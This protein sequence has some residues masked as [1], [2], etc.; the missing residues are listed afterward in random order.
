MIKCAKCGT[1]IFDKDNMVWECKS[2]GKSFKANLSKLKKIQEQKDKIENNGKRLLKCS[3]CGNGLDDGDEKIICKCSECENVIT[4]N[5]KFFSGKNNEDIK[6]NPNLI[7]CP[8]CGRANVSKSAETCPDCG[9]GIKA[10]EEEKHKKEELRKL[11]EK[12][13]KERKRLAEERAKEEQALLDSMP[14]PQK[15]FPWQPLLG[16]FFAVGAIF[17]FYIGLMSYI[18][19]ILLGLFEGFIAFCLIVGGYSNYQDRRRIY[20]ISLHDME[21]A[22]KEALALDRMNQAIVAEKN[23][24]IMNAVNPFKEVSNGIKCPMC[25]KNA[26]KRISTTSRAVSVATV[27]LASG[28]IGKQYKCSSCGHMW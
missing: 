6:R 22:K 13:G 23:A 8:E 10:H 12:W 2:C 26:G 5:L 20:E 11:E 19:F 17:M 27:G 15:P 3:V 9:Y 25:G 18:G 7:N 21:R 28:K 24:K 16:V 14:T 4:R 1:V